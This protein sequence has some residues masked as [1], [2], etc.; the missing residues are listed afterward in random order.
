MGRRNGEGREVAERE[1]G[2]EGTHRNL[3]N[4]KTIDVP[5]I[6]VFNTRYQKE[7]CVVSFK[8]ETFCGRRTTATDIIYVCYKPRESTLFSRLF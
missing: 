6:V 8:R 5:K 4:R 1:T 7:E 2:L 3:R